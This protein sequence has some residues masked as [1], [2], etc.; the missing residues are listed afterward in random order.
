MVCSTSIRNPSHRL[1][2]SLFFYTLIKKKAN[3]NILNN[4]LSPLHK[5]SYASEREFTMRLAFPLKAALKLTAYPASNRLIKVARA[6][7]PVWKRKWACL[8]INTHAWQDV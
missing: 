1:K 6:T 4:S 8:A 2:I 7:L 3:A 5:I